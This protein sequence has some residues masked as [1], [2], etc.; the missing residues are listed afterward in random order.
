MLS[1][2]EWRALPE[3]HPSRPAGVDLRVFLRINPRHVPEN[4]PQWAPHH[5][6]EGSLRPERPLWTMVRSPLGL[7]FGDMPWV[8]SEE[9]PQVYSGGSARVDFGEGP[10]FGSA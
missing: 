4:Q 1:A 6:P 5:R 3:I 9:N 10:P 8:D 2:A 7:I